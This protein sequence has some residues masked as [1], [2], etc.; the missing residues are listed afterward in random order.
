MEPERNS[1]WLSSFVR[2][3]WSPCQPLSAS[4]C[5]LAPSNMAKGTGT[6]SKDTLTLQRC[7]LVKS[8]SPHPVSVAVSCPYRSIAI[9]GL[10]L[11]MEQAVTG[12]WKELDVGTS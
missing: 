10:S 11:A 6:D 8:N 7:G 5:Q 4:S 2:F 9:V 3:Q 12:P 1:L